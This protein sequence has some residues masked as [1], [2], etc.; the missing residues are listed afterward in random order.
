MHGTVLCACPPSEAHS[1][2][3]LHQVLPKNQDKGLV[4]DGIFQLNHKV[5]LHEIKLYLTWLMHLNEV[6]TR[7]VFGSFYLTWRETI[8]GIKTKK[9]P[10]NLQRLYHK[11]KFSVVAVRQQGFTAC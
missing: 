4:L 1:T 7:L 6:T 3:H 11:D 9:I 2:H 5:S 10:R 8:K